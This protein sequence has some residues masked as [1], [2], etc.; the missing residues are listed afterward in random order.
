MFPRALWFFGIKSRKA[1]G[2]S[3]YTARRCFIDNEILL[4]I[5]HIN[6]AHFVVVGLM[7]VDYSVRVKSEQ[8]RLP[9]SLELLS[10]IYSEHKIT[11]SSLPQNAKLPQK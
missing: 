6:Q 11:G 4:S 8:A 3:L 5:P 1:Y 7:G 2:A 10:N 9:N